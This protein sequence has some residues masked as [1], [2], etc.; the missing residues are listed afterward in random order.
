M[1]NNR[2][3]KYFAGLNG[4]RFFAAYLVVLHHAEQIRMKYDMFNWKTLSIFNQGDTGVTFFF[5][6][7]GFLIT[8]LL[9]KEEFVTKNISIRNF[10]VRRVLRI[11]PLYFLLVAIGLIFLPYILQL[12]NFKYDM[13]YTFSQTIF[14][15]IFF[16]PFV[17]NILFGHHLL[18]PLWSIGVEE[19]FYL[20]WA[21]LV[22]FF[23]KYVLPLILSVI[24]IKIALGLFVY[25]ADINNIF[26]KIVYILE[27]EAMAI[28]GIAA[29]LVFNLTEEIEHNILFSKQIQIIMFIIVITPIFFRDFLIENLFIAKVIFKTPV[30][31]NLLKMTCFAWL[32]VNIA[33]NKKTII[34]LENKLFNFL[35]D[36]SYGIYMYHMLII[37]AVTLFFAKYFNMLNNILASIIFYVIITAAT[38]V[39][40]Y[41]SKKLYEDKFLSLKK[42]FE[43]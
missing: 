30:F 3:I 10:Y 2:T 4:L 23:K 20:M 42:K 28:G 39:L 15:F 37:F 13:P 43:H 16:T 5:V 8:Y 26:A 22:K 12:L 25:F 29:Y 40:S 33:I 41:L 9:L 36:I 7:S 34:K 24:L 17:V 18:E 38:I 32:I 1:L 21:P 35:G 27:F 14:Y 6:L 31:S 19:I 11:W